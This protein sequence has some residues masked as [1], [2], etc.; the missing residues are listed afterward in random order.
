MA[1]N[2]EQIKEIHAAVCGDDNLG[3]KLDKILEKLAL[4][5]KLES[6]HDALG[7]EVAGISKKIEGLEQKVESKRTKMVPVQSTQVAVSGDKPALKKEKKPAG[8]TPNAKFNNY[9]VN[10]DDDHK[11]FE[12]VSGMSY[13]DAFNK[14][15]KTAKKYSKLKKE[16]LPES[17]RAMYLKY[18]S[19]LKVYE[20]NAKD[21][22]CDG[23]RKEIGKVAYNLNCVRSR[24]KEFAEN[25]TAIEEHCK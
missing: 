2:K 15:I 19:L 24:N 7:E 22:N 11:L 5:E 4:L 14:Y 13:E 10:V 21:K 23:V 9:M 25:K 17:D 20:K 3:E 6:Y 12:K 16:D 1:A 18:E 8:V